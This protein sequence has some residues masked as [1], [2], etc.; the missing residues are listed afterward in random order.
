MCWSQSRSV[1][2]TRPLRTEEMYEEERHS[3]GQQHCSRL[4]KVLVPLAL[5]ARKWLLV[6]EDG[7]LFLSLHTCKCPGVVVD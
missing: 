1:R 5:Y 6:F 3:D 4:E 7:L 2:V